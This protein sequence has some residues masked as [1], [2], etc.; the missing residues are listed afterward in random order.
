MADALE[1]SPTNSQ[2]CRFCRQF[3]SQK[4]ASPFFTVEAWTLGVSYTSSP[5]VLQQCRLV[6]GC[7]G[8]RRSHTSAPYEF[9][10]YSVFALFPW[11]RPAVE[12][13]N[14]QLTDPAQ[15][16]VRQYRPYKAIR[17]KLSLS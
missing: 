11:G 1:G 7:G 17:I 8:A 12:E 2:G 4:E 10:I 5:S 16:E 3:K 14:V 9:L 13:R 6:L 15:S